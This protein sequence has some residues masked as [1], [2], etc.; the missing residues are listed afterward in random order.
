MWPPAASG[1]LTSI[2]PWPPQATQFSPPTTVAGGSVP[3][4]Y[5][6]EMVP[7][8]SASRSPPTVPTQLIAP[9]CTVSLRA[10]P[11][12]I[13]FPPW[14]VVSWASKRHTAALGSVPAAAGAATPIM[15]KASAAASARTV[16]RTDGR[17]A[18]P[19]S[20]QYRTLGAPF[21]AE[22]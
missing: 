18:P 19:P 6:Y 10:D 5:Q 14:V 2:S 7:G 21:R 22:P 3:P 11:G 13:Q 9:G 20:R 16:V 8:A 1:R 17:T 15:A 4:T 12:V